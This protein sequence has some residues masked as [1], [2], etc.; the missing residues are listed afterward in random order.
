MDL[1]ATGLA[2]A[3]AGWMLRIAWRDFWTLRISNRDVAV[4]LAMALLTRAA[5]G[6]PGGWADLAAGALLFV[7]GVLFWLMRMMGAGDAKLY[8]PLGILIGWAGLVPFAV[9]LLPVSLIFM[10]LVALGPRVLPGGWAAVARLA[11]IRAQRRVPYG[12]PMV[13]T[14]LIVMIPLLH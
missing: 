3:C 13:A 12:V 11:Q 14:A 5:M 6:F 10:G 2:L 8:L 7:M 1:A 9:L 4:L